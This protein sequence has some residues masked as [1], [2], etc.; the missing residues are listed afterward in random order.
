MYEESLFKKKVF[1]KTLNAALN[2]KREVNTYSMKQVSISSY[3]DKRR[4]KQ[5]GIDSYA[6]GHYNIS[7]IM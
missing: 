6:Y 3:E 5:N 7:T 2:V 4:Y 1:G